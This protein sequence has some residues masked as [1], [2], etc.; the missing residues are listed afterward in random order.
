MSGKSKVQLQVELDEA[1]D[2][3]ERS[4][5]EVDELQERL[6]SILELAV[7]ADDPPELESE[8]EE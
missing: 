5:D 2:Q 6:D 3:V 7:D 8:S 1:L 4:Q